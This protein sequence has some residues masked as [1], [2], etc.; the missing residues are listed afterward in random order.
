MAACSLGGITVVNI[1]YVIN[2]VDIWMKE[3]CLTIITFLI[4][5]IVI[6]VALWFLIPMMG[7]DP[8]RDAENLRRCG[9]NCT[10]V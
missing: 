3:N 4:S 1:V 9:E 2:R 8:V 10:L 5:L 7:I 6:L